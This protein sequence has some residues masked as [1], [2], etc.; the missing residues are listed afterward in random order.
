MKLSIS[1]ICRLPVHATAA[2]TRIIVF[3]FDRSFGFLGIPCI[4]TRVNGSS[5]GP[6][7]IFKFCRGGCWKNDDFIRGRPRVINVSVT[8]GATGGVGKRVMVGGGKERQKNVLPTRARTTPSNNAYNSLKW[9]DATADTFCAYEVYA[10]YTYIQ[11]IMHHVNVICIY[12]HMYINSYLILHDTRAR[13]LQVNYTPLS[14]VFR[15][16]SY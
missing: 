1:E 12:I 16:N 2:L 3:S 6:H 8:R 5:R 7:K 10:R 11:N 9:F 15:Q 4:R 14:F 13:K